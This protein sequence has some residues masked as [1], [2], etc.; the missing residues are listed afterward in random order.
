[1][2]VKKNKNKNSI[3][4]HKSVFPIIIA[5]NLLP[6]VHYWWYVPGTSGT[7]PQG[8]SLKKTGLGTIGQGR[9]GSAR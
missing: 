8:T 7:H 2:C 1:M 3:I 4:N 9:A 5:N 6:E